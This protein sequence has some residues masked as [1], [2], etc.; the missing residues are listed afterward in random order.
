M[1]HRIY[2]QI[3]DAYSHPHDSGWDIR[4]DESKTIRPP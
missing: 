1:M 4:N 2:K 3:V